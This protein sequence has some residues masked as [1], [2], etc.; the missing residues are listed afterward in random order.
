[1]FGV[2]PIGAFVEPD[3][4][5]LR[6]LDAERQTRVLVAGSAANLFTSLLVF[7]VFLAFLYATVPFKESGLLVIGGNH[8]GDVLH[9]INGVDALTFLQGASN[10]TKYNSTLAFG[11][12][13]GAY[14][15]TI[16]KGTLYDLSSMFFLARYSNPAL[17][18]IYNLLGLVFSLNFVIGMVN[19]LPLPLF[20]GYRVMEINVDKKVVVTAV[21]L[22][23]ALAFVVNFLPW[24]F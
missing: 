5:Q 19:L 15:G 13:K 14:S 3:E 1:M 7:F 18:F 6:K 9:T 8:T 22:V 10:Q 16:T 4:D 12:D 24:L 21:S 17:Q 20:D 23:T 2:L 11:S